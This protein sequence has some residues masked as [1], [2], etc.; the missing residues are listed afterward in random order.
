ME[1]RS[2]DWLDEMRVTHARIK[3]LSAFAAFVERYQ[4]SLFRVAKRLVNSEGGTPDAARSGTSTM[5]RKLAGSEG[6]AGSATRLLQVPNDASLL[7]T[8]FSL[9]TVEGFSID[10]AAL[11][12]DDPKRGA[13]TRLPLAKSLSWLEM[14]AYFDS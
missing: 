2:N 3:A 13:M 8:V 5:W 1:P 12:F 10:K 6:Q 14:R 7:C 9:R 11:K 4:G